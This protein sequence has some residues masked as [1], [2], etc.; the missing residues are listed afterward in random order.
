MAAD[1]QTNP[2]IIVRELIQNSMDASLEAGRSTCLVDFVLEDA[3]LQEIPGI[4][5]YRVALANAKIAHKENIEAAEATI[6]RFENCL[7]KQCIPVLSVLDN[8]IGL[9]SSRMHSLLG[10]GTSDK[11]G[12]SS[13]RG[14]SF[15][16][17]H[18]TTFPA[19]DLRYIIYGGVTKNGSTCMSGHAVLASHPPPPPIIVQMVAVRR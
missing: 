9:D 5:S 3:S 14:G 6:E 2:A 18:Y 16:V 11:T 7:K 8:G 19:S 10:D 15:G 17:G 4:E 12:A 13:N 1:D